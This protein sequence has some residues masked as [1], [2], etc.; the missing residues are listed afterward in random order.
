M[1]Q[2]IQVKVI[3][4]MFKG[5]PDIIIRAALM[6]PMKNSLLKPINHKLFVTNSDYA[7]YEESTIGGVL[8][9]NCLES[10][11]SKGFKIP[12]WHTGETVINPILE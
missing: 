2:F 10:L 9:V 3:R 11:K 8:T 1:H 4:T 5:F 6:D 12:D 7:H